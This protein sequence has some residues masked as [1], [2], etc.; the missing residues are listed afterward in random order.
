LPAKIQ[1]HSPGNRAWAVPSKRR[2]YGYL[3]KL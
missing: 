2:A 3:M 1:F